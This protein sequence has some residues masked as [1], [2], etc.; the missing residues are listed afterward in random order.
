MYFNYIYDGS[1]DGLLTALYFSFKTEKKPTYIG[2]LEHNNNFLDEN[3]YIKTDT[4]KATKVYTG[5][6]N[7]L[8]QE[9]LRS[10]FYS[11]LSE[12]ENHGMIIYNFLKDGFKFGR[13]FIDFES[14][15]HVSNLRT[16]R[17][18]VAREV[19]FLLGLVRFKELKQEIYYAQIKPDYNSIGLIAPHFSQRLNDQYWIIHDVGRGLGVFYDKQQWIIKSIDSNLRIE[20]T[21]TEKKYQELWKTYFSHIAIKNRINPKLQRQNMPKKYWDFLIEMNP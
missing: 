18:R 1:F 8:S 21:E 4:E 15:I 17:R 11:Y 9:A 20:F 3:I 7:T 5:I 12:D 14:N 10:I 13:G 6:R 19:H 2:Y 16:L